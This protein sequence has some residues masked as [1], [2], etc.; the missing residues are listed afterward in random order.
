VLAKRDDRPRGDELV[1]ALQPAS[2][3][4]RSGG[5]A[6]VAALAR[7]PVWVPWAVAGVSI[8]V[9]LLFAVLYVTR[10]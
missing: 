9:A 6:L 8:L 1:G 3:S 4:G 10:R 7:T 5:G 2:A